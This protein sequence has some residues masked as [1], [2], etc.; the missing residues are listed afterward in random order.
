MDKELKILE[1]ADYKEYIEY[2]DCSC[3]L[4]V[5]NNIEEYNCM[6]GF[7]K[8]TENFENVKQLFNKVEKRAK[9]LGFKNI[10]GPVNY[11]TWMSYRWA[12]NNFDVKYY[13]DCNNAEYYVKY[14]RKLGYK[15]LYTYRSA[16][17][18]MNNKLYFMGDAVYKLK[19]AEGYEFKFFKGE[20]GYKIVKDIYDISIDAFKGSYLYSDIPFEYFNEIYLE[21]TKKIEDI[22]MYVAYK[23]GK[24][25]GYI[26]GYINPYNKNEIIA[27]TSA[28]LKE[29]QQH[30]VYVALLFL[31][32]KYAK[33]IGYKDMVYHFQ[34]EQ[35]NTFQRFDDNI[36]SDEKKYAVFVKEL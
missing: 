3:Y 4:I 36:E 34:C 29:Y 2:E 27:K 12:I 21:W 25:I 23:E 5:N 22:V 18:D 32:C 31:G 1:L 7:V 8:L 17:I 14:I 10:I 26:M 20:E 6:F 9:E 35:K 33:E 28:V 16:H 15:E 24:P 30:K 13:P 11:T 19:L